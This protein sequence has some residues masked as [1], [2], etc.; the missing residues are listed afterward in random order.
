[1][2]EGQV[3]AV[4]EETIAPMPIGK[5]L[6]I[7]IVGKYR[8]AERKSD[9]VRNERISTSRPVDKLHPWLR[10]GEARIGARSAIAPKQIRHDGDVIHHARI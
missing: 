1:M 7:G 6:D 9:A 3:I 5:L 2:G 8:T 10:L 4:P